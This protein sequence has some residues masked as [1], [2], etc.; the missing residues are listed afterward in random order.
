MEKESIGFK[1]KNYNLARRGM[2]EKFP[3]LF[4][5]LELVLLNQVIMA[6]RD[7]SNRVGGGAM[8]LVAGC[9][10]PRQEV[11]RLEQNDSNVEIDVETVSNGKLLEL[12]EYL[13]VTRGEAQEARIVVP[14]SDEV[15]ILLSLLQESWV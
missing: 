8:L 7:V 6:S 15:C 3:W 9:G 5:R 14:M 10:A 12:Q 13:D 11:T 1:M 2:E 4:Q